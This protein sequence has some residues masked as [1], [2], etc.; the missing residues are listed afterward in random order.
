[1]VISILLLSNKLFY[2]ISMLKQL[3][4]NSNEILFKEFETFKFVLF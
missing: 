3:V 2:K 1:M 4:L